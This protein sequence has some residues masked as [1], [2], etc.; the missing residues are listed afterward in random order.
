MRVT[1]LGTTQGPEPGR[2]KARPVEGDSG[3]FG[4]LLREAVEARGTRAPE[5]P[6]AVSAVD[7]LLAAQEVPPP[8]PDQRRRQAMA[9]GE[10][11]LEHLDDLRDALLAGAVSKD[12]LGALAREV[13]A[14]REAVDDGPLAEVLDEIDVRAQ[15]ELAKLTRDS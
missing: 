14:R 13:R 5:S 3:G 2:R 12:Q 6:H 11:L 15:V 9:R 8:D 4:D 1:H 10:R 7:A